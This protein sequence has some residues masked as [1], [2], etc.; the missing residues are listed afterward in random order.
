MLPGSLARTWPASSLNTAS[1]SGPLPS[2]TFSV[3]TIPIMFLSLGSL[4]EPS[5]RRAAPPGARP[6]GSVRNSEGRI[7]GELCPRRCVRSG[8]EAGRGG[9]PRVVRRHELAEQHDAG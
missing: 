5:F 9:G 6:E 1:K 2:W 4:V 7:V 3:A 8:H